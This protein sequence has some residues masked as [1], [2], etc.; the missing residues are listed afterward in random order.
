MPL[1]SDDNAT[2]PATATCKGMLCLP[3][4]W[5]RTCPSLNSPDINAHAAMLTHLLHATESLTA[6]DP[7]S[8]VS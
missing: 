3:F 2:E 1:M 7:G 4:G 8:E 6:F 5:Q